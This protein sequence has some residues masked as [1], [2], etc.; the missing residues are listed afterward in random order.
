MRNWITA[1]TQSWPIFLIAAVLVG[2]LAAR[3]YQGKRPQ[4]ILRIFLAV[5]LAGGI[6][7][8]I[9]LGL[10][11]LRGAVPHMWS[12]QLATVAVIM[13]VPLVL[14]LVTLALWMRVRS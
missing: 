7:L 4:S 1:H 11:R 3:S 10:D 6:A 8:Y 13:A 12:A 14:L 9:D 5:W 2:V